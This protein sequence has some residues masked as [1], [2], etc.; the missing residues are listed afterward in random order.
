MEKI[1]KLSKATRYESAI[2]TKK[3]PVRRGN[4]KGRSINMIYDI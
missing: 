1:T 3:T 4:G 2:M